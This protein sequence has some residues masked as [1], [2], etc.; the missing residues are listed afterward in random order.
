MASALETNFSYTYPGILTTEVFFKPVED[1]PALSDLAIIDQGI[2]Y[3]KQYNVLPQL[4][5]ILKPYDGCARTF[6][7]TQEI[8]NKTLETKEFEA[9]LEW[10][11]DD[12]TNY[13]T[14]EYNYLAQ[15]MLK[16]GIESF[17]PSGT[18]V[19]SMINRLIDEALRQDVFRRICFGDSGSASADF[20]TID[21]IWTQLIDNSG[22]SSTYCVRRASGTSLGT[23]A[24]ASGEAL[25][26]L[27][28]VY[29]E[30]ANI[31]KA[32]PT[33]KKAM[34]VTG[35]IYD[36]Y[37]NSLAANG[38]VT[39]QAFTNLIKGVSSLTF[40]GIPVIPVRIW[41]TMLEDASNPLNAT[42]RHLVLY[43]TKDNHRIG[44]E[45]SGDL[46]K[47]EGFYDRK[48][49]KYYFEADMK[50]GYTYLHCDLQ[51]IAY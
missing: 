33:N 11:K 44:V 17:D 20:D 45:N 6:S 19:A 28:A 8:T 42:T 49:R 50:F 9:N 16:S 5:K 10:C 35:S 37:F 24:L 13:L 12:F 1:S 21:G 41:D 40:K 46:N 25:T 31:L 30:S 14:N 38:S 34:F 32:L 51:T 3:K 7:G 15:E 2:S 23:S 22:T 27:E 26:T 43:T 39:E 36:N 18:P 47:V 4:S 48:D 29:N